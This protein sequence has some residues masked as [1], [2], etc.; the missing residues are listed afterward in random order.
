M[1]SPR[2]NGTPGGGVELANPPIDRPAGMSCAVVLGALR[3]ARVRSAARRSA[4]W[5]RWSAVRNTVNVTWPRPP[6]RRLEE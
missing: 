4:G 6:T 3:G 2:S 5:S 1:S